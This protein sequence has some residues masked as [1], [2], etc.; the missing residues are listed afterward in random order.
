MSFPQEP[1]DRMKR[2]ILLIEYLLS[3]DDAWSNAEDSMQA[4]AI[5]MLTAVAADFRLLPNAET[6]VLLSPQSRTQL[7]AAGRIDDQWQ[8]E[9]I[10]SGPATWLDDRGDRADAV[11][12]MLVIAPECNGLLV[13]LLQ[14]I[15]TGA[16]K[17]VRCL[18]LDS[19]RAAVFAD[20]RTTAEWLQKHRISTPETKA[21]GDQLAGELLFRRKRFQES[22][23]IK[24]RHGAGSDRVN[25]ISMS[26]SEFDRLRD[27]PSD[28]DVDWILQPLVPG[29]ACSV[30]LIGGGADRPT[31]ILPAARQD[32][33][34]FHDQFRYFG[35]TI[36][37]EEPLA[38]VVRPV[39]EQ[40]AAALGPFSGFVG[41]DV[42]V[43]TAANG[44]MTA[45]LIEINPRLCTSYVGYRALC[46]DNLAACLLQ[47]QAREH[48]RWKYEAVDFDTEG[49]VRRT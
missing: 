28:P 10:T 31:M 44:D 42:V 26:R 24:P 49:R 1:H 32:V 34:K 20:K 3:D 23:V 40:V 35:G 37:C 14:Q 6:T 13:S 9:E 16:W 47:L 19:S 43:S 5:A 25:V 22:F 2:R 7:N 21:V 8:I 41:I 15:Q 11:D 48:L 18:N 45:Q 30:G 17:H 46:E 38:G 36:P 29:D 4:E 33:R 39:A 12:A 27:L